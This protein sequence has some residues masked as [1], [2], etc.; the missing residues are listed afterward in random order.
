MR[1][2]GRGGG[3]VTGGSWGAYWYN[4]YIYS[5]EIDRGFDI[6]ELTPSEFLSANEIAAAKLVRFERYNPQSQPKIV[7]PAAFPVVRSYLDQLG[8]NN[9]LP[10]ARRTAITQTL[11]TAEGQSGAARRTTLTALATALD[12]DAAAAT[13]A[14]RVRAMAQAVRDLANATR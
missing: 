10:A 13:D 11:R 6:Y 3:G 7:W 4:G 9:G 8:R 2:G 14:K 1:G 12:G 5:N